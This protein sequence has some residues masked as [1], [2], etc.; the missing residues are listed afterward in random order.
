MRLYISHGP[1]SSRRCLYTESSQTK[2][3]VDIDE[4]KN[5]TKF[6]VSTQP[7][8]KDSF[9]GITIGW[10]RNECPTVKYVLLNEV[11]LTI[12]SSHGL[13]TLARNFWSLR[14]TTAVKL[15]HVTRT[16]MDHV[17]V[18]WHQIYTFDHARAIRIAR[19][20]FK[21]HSGLRSSVCTCNIA[22]LCVIVRAVSREC[23]A[24]QCAR[25]NH[26]YIMRFYEM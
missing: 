12:R 10:K 20:M 24:P 8:W 6:N 19:W 23:A 1:N 26:V 16:L 11:L 4:I 5:R 22:I 17:I 25:V 9:D 7:H 21:L 18:T 15:S 2:L 3:K 13:T 14:P